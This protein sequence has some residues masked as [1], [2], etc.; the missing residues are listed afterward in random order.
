M[1]L[2]EFSRSWG[3]FRTPHCVTAWETHVAY[4][5][6][7]VCFQM[8]WGFLPVCFLFQPDTTICKKIFKNVI[9]V[10]LS[11][12]IWHFLG[13]KIKRNY[14]N[15]EWKKKFVAKRR[16]FYIVRCIKTPVNDRKSKQDKN[17][18]NPLKTRAK[19]KRVA[20]KYHLRENTLHH[21]RPRKVG[22]TG[23]LVFVNQ[24]I[25]AH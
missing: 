25:F 15:G 7:S 8:D 23:Y 24:H 20:R 4:I 2:G 17:L 16:D 22:A 5:F 9:L 13:P 10:I 21:P 3:Y 19:N 1:F 18:Q 11:Q 12:K 6:Y 14:F